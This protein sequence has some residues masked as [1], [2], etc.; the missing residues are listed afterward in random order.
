MTLTERRAGD[1]T[2]LD[3]TGRLVLEDGDAVLR[4]R[5]NALLA[6]G[7]LKIVIN[8]RDVTYIDSCGVGVLIAKFVSARRKGG[9]VRLL[10]LTPRSHHVME[11]TRL[12]DVFQIFASE[13]DAVRSFAPS[14]SGH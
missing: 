5:V 3:L 8:L 7:R 4:E 1:V 13:E 12:L 9:D 10:H 2:L 6:E 14:P 11:I